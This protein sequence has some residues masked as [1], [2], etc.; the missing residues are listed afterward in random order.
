M[1]S[2]FLLGFTSGLANSIAIW[3]ICLHGR[4]LM[5]SLALMASFTHHIS[6]PS[7]TA[8]FSSSSLVC[9]P[10]LH[11]YKHWAHKHPKQ[12]GMQEDK[13]LWQF[14]HCMSYSGRLTILMGIFLPCKW[15]QS[16]IEWCHHSNVWNC[17]SAVLF[18]IMQRPKCVS[19]PYKPPSSLSSSSSSSSSSSAS[20]PR[21]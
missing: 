16:T 19:R 11:T 4:F 5:G 6:E 21:V 9:Y 20:S 2:A 13:C 7:T 17:S 18:D 10:S 8:I 1:F 15:I 3:E 12:A 14:V